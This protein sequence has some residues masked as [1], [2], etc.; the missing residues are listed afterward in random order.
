MEYNNFKTE[1]L[2]DLIDIKD[3]L[4]KGKKQV[5]DKDNKDKNNKNIKK[6]NLNKKGEN[7][8]EDK[9]T[10]KEK[11]KM[12]TT[13]KVIIIVSSSFLFLTG[14]GLFLLYGPWAWFRETLIT[15]AMT[16]LSHQY[17]ATWF[18]SDETIK[19]VLDKNR[20]GN[21][22]GISNLN[23]ITITKYDNTVKNYAN[24]YDEQ[25]LKK[26]EGND[27]YKVIE[28]TGPS[29]KGY[30]VA[31]YDPSKVEIVQSKYLG[32]QGEL[33][34]TMARD[35]NAAV[36]ING[37]G[38]IDPNGTSLGGVPMGLAIRDGQL[39]YGGYNTRSSLIGITKDNK[40]LLGNMTASEAFNMG[41]EDAIEF[42]PYLIVNG[43]P[44]TIY[45]NG[46]WGYGPRTAIGQRKDGIILMVVING[47]RVT[48]VG[49]SIKELQEI[50]I[51][52]GAYNAANLDGGSSSTLVVENE[53]INNPV[54]ATP[55][56]MRNIPNAII[57]KK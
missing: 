26:D 10:N 36:A 6:Q 18:Y 48:S 47:R 50:M 27:L 11:K 24:K 54:A 49:A 21:A 57:V 14:S 22:N 41:I 43:R 38:F 2:D 39:L 4:K 55:S 53:V 51:N 17:L 3:N 5:K 9:K 8:H 13:K 44:T 12:S 19:E 56:G 1:R 45:G 34:T 7:N 23:E 28:L 20:V 29:Y 42:R 31:V 25:I 35:N 30:L 32:N 16:T 52:Y 33:I 37:G 15:T 46:G 40:L